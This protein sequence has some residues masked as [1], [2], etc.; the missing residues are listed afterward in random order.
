MN[1][2]SL[3]MIPRLPYAPE[4]F[5]IH[6]GAKAAYQALL[7]TIESKSY[8][9][10][11][12]KSQPRY[13]K[14]HFTVKAV[15]EVLERKKYPRLIEGKN[16]SEFLLTDFPAYQ[17]NNDQV[18]IIDDAEIYFKG[19][20]PGD[21]GEFVN[22]IERLRLQ[23]NHVVFLSA[24]KPD[25]LPCDDHVKS[26][27]KA[28]LISEIDLPDEQDMKTIVNLMSRQRGISLNDKRLDYISRRLRREIPYI[29]NYFD[30]VSHLSSV[31]SRSV[32]RPLLANA[33]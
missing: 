10:A 19:V 5:F 9:V 33:L 11:Y 26:R 3:N 30:R 6:Q 14:T 29:E 4:N 1:Q 15:Q 28:G 8:S 25:D 27:L 31:L 18:F 12:I 13:G 22:F 17:L 2:L 21:S 24:E 7:D 16:F 32:T 23:S 20:H